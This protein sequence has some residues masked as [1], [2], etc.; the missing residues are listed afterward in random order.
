MMIGATR[1]EIKLSNFKG[2]EKFLNELNELVT[3]KFEGISTIRINSE[4]GNGSSFLLNAIANELRRSGEK[5]SFTA[6]SKE[7]GSDDLLAHQYR[8]LL[9]SSFIFIDDLHH[10]LQHDELKIKFEFL[11]RDFAANGGKLVYTH[12]SQ[13]KAENECFINEIFS[14]LVLNWHLVP[15]DG[16]RRRLWSLEYLNE[17]E[18]KKI[19]EGLFHSANSNE[20]FLRSLEPFIAQTKLNRGLN[21]SDIRQSEEKLYDLEL[22]MLRNKL[23]RLE[24]Q[25]VK[26]VFIREQ[27]YERAADI[28]EQQIVLSAEL[29]EIRFEIESLKI[30]PSPSEAAMRLYINYLSVKNMLKL[31]EQSLRFAVE[32]MKDQLDELNNFKKELDIMINK[33]ERLKLFQEIVNWT[34][35][36]DKF[37]LRS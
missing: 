31:H 23:A 35:T 37:L 9:M 1:F 32:G 8:N 6:I 29:E 19:P 10:L 28:R 36:L 26:N 17:Q 25:P 11:L 12:R 21:Y 33:E 34:D 30:T 18:V 4:S 22:R 13:E 3:H 2:S 20:D 7:V 16:E 14:G 15:L 27:R 24:L 5:I